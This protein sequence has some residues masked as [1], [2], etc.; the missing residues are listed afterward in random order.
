MK[1]ICMEETGRKIRQCIDESGFTVKQVSEKL[2]LHIMSVYKW[3]YGAG[4]PTI[5]NLVNLADILDVKIE[6]LLVVESVE[7]DSIY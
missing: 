1:T 7:D 2:N 6:D 5:D 3:T 4:L